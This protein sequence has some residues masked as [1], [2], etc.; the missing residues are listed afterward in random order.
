MSC[1]VERRPGRAGRSRAIYPLGTVGVGNRGIQ[2]RMGTW[3]D[4]VSD[5]DWTEGDALVV[6]RDVSEKVRP[7]SSLPRL[8]APKWGVRH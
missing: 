2:R 5:R 8:N 1:R 6:T 7:E 3:C 4:M